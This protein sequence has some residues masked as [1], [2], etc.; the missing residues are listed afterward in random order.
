MQKMQNRISGAIFL[1]KSKGY[2]VSYSN[3]ERHER[4]KN[5]SYSSKFSRK[6]YNQHHS[7]ALLIFKEYLGVRYGEIVVLVDVMNAIQVRQ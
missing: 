4:I 6:D 3:N 5:P 2:Q 7:L 1:W